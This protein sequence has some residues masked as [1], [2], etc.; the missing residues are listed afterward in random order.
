MAKQAD[1]LFRP[2]EIVASRFEVLALV[3]T[4]AMGQVY[5]CIDRA[6]ENNEVALKI[7]YPHQSSDPQ[8]SARFKN[9]V[10]VAR[11]L[12]HPNIV[13]VHDLGA[14]EN[15]SFF[16]SMEFIEGESL[17]EL[18]L[19]QPGARLPFEQALSVLQ[20]IAQGMA[21][22]H[23]LGVIHRDLKPENILISKSG[24]VKISD[25]GLARNVSMDKRLTATGETV[26]T[27]YYMSPE[28]IRGEKLDARTDI[29]SLGIMG[30][31]LVSGLHPFQDDSWFGL[32][33]KHLQ[34]P[35]PDFPHSAS[36]PKW[37][38]KVIRRCCDKSRDERYLTAAE[39]AGDLQSRSYST[40]KKRKWSRP[41]IFAAVILM[42]FAAAIV[43]VDKL[44]TS[45]RL[46]E[47]CKKEVTSY[48][49]DIRPGGGRIIDCLS[50]HANELS[51]ECRKRLP[52]PKLPFAARPER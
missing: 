46:T 18:V 3:G 33:T 17:R 11:A 15:D 40:G 30:Y 47:A 1:P 37:F 24:V 20:A 16:L 44:L 4:G 22:A 42:A 31:E 23:Q 27:P 28:Q 41:A 32:A 50:R 45:V 34:Q 35:L 39:L 8:S 52:P 2:G 12:S 29:Y 25:F 9:E 10:L 19:R 7:L 6:L 21:H 26:G 48:C 14:A 13:R 49:S 36:V 43:T 38:V 51:A 5:R